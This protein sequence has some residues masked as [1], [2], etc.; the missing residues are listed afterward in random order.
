MNL[1]A[2]Q[3]FARNIINGELIPSGKWILTRFLLEAKPKQNLPEKATAAY[4]DR[5]SKA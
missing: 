5:F 3:S 1:W 2:V 4:G